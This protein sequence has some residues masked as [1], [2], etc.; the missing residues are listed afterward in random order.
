MWFGLTQILP[1]KGMFINFSNF[2]YQQL[3]ADGSPNPAQQKALGRWLQA[4]DKPQTFT[5]LHIDNGT[6]FILWLWRQ[7]R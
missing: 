1:G 5:H 3:C 6:I 7:I 4:Y 2:I